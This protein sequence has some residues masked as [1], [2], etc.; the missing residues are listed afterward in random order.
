MLQFYCMVL[1]DMI[2]GHIDIHRIISILTQPF[3]GVEEDY[4]EISNNII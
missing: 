2:I 1:R 4:I 3:E